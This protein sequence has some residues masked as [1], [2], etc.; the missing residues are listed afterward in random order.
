MKSKVDPLIKLL[1]F[2]Q[3]EA[4]RALVASQD[5]LQQLVQ[6]QKSLEMS[7]VNG[8]RE[9]D[10]LQRQPSIP[11]EHG[12][13]HHWLGKVRVMIV[14]KGKE[15]VAQQGVVEQCREALAAIHLELKTLEKYKENQEERLK[16]EK[17]TLDAKELDEIAGQK[18][19]RQEE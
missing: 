13:Y 10:A 15:V 11:E 14:E 6:D 16:L 4:S 19:R 5:R 18:H 17:K 7:L 2:R 8:E 12:L 3:G 1:D 9:F